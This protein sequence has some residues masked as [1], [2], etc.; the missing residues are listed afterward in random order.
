MTHI[1]AAIIQFCV[2]FVTFTWSVW[3][4]SLVFVPLFE[5]KKMLRDILSELK[6][7]SKQ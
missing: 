7:R 1:Q 3:F 5:I 6:K 2:V 4:I